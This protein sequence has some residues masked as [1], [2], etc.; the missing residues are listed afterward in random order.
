MTTFSNQKI[1]KSAVVRIILG[2]IIC[3]ATLIIGQQ[4]FLKIPEIDTLSTNIRNLVKGIFVS[5]LVIGSYG[6][7]YH[8]YE[9]R[10]ITEL[11][12]TGLG[13]N[14]LIGIV[15]GSVLQTLTILVIYLF[16]YFIVNTVNPVNTL[17]IPFTIAFT[18]AILE[19]I[20]LRG[21]VFRIAEEKLGSVIAILI[22]CVIFVGLHLVNPHV[23]LISLLCILAVGVLLAAAYIYI[24]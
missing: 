20:L 5:I 19:E 13:K 24:L 8:K 21:I 17:I 4:I 6:F 10:K 1:L 16:G 9:R 14:L 7:F 18:I 23:T 15:T 22:S 11:S 12:T 2:L 3:V